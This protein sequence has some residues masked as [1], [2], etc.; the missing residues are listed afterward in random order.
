MP[1]NIIKESTFNLEL[2]EELFKTLI[3]TIG[4]FAPMFLQQK[5]KLTERETELLGGLYDEAT[6]KFGR[7]FFGFTEIR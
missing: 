4:H 1:N 6:D 3:K 2:S 7:K 5:A